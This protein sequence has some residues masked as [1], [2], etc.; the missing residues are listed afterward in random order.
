ML[1][2]LA[3]PD[4]DV[5]MEGHSDELAQKVNRLE[6]QMSQVMQSQQSVEIKISGMQQQIDQQ[7]SL[8][9]GAVERQ[10][11][12]QMDKIESLLSKRNR[13]E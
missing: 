4:E 11:Q 6:A 10:M 8:F 2:K 13:L 7:H 9:A 12:E 3:R 5:C 1:E